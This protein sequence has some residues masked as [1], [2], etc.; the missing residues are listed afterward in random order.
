MAVS[1]SDVRRVLDPEEPNYADVAQLGEEALP[2]LIAL[3]SGEDPMLA[4]KAVWAA[5]L[6]QNSAGADVVRNA[7]HSDDS[8]LRIA[9]AAAARNLPIDSAI[10]ILYLL[11][12]DNDPGI[13][14]V[15]RTSADQLDTD[16]PS[17]DAQ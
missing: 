9:A 1:M 11:A 4:S 5:S 16:K 17:S 2:H 15:A 13:Q 3:V 8:V 6:L 12:T 14:K 7:A 10:E